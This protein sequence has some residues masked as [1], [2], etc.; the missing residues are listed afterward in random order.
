MQFIDP[1]R[2]L[3]IDLTRQIEK[4]GVRMALYPLGQLAEVEMQR[5]GHRLPAR[6]I[7]DAALSM[8]VCGSIQMALTGT[9]TASGRPSRSLIIPRS[10][11]TGSSRKNAYL[12]VL[13]DY[14]ER[15]FAASP[16]GPAA[17][18]DNREWPHKP[19]ANRGKAG[20]GLHFSLAP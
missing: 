9:L 4:A 19:E 13:P 15:Q 6:A 8:V 12:L 11:A 17:V 5:F 10:T 1:L 18:P 7:A 16:R 2:L 20:G 3:G 14:R